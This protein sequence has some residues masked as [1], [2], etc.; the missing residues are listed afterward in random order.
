MASHSENHA[1]ERLG[2]GSNMAE[3]FVA[4]L[5]HTVPIATYNKVFA[6]LIFL[7]VLTVWA[8]TQPVGVIAHIFIAILIATIK[9]SIVGFYFMHLKYE[10]ATTWSVAIC[11]FAIFALLVLGTLGDLMVKEAPQPSNQKISD[12]KMP[13]TV[14]KEAHH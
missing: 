8:A 5:G 9:A 3:D 4:G 7:T 11:P 2:D 1:G 14:E 12:V 6:A 10:G 13:S